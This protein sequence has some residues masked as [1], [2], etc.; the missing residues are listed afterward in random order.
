MPAILDAL[1]SAGIVV[2]T[3]DGQHGIETVHDLIVAAIRPVKRDIF[4]SIGTVKRGLDVDDSVPSSS[5]RDGEV[6]F[7]K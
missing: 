3:I 6:T 4:A 5:E 2:A 1:R 7:S